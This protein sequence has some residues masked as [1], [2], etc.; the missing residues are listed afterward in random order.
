MLMMGRTKK[1]SRPKPT[2]TLF[3]LQNLHSAQRQRERLLSTFPS[4]HPRSHT[5]LSA[6]VQISHHREK[7]GAPITQHSKRVAI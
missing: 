5:Q 2:G 7:N 4:L 6:G 3:I 1:R